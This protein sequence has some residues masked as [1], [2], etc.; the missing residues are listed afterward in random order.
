MPPMAPLS[1]PALPDLNTTDALFN[2]T[3]A[4]AVIVI[5]P[6]GGDGGS[7]NGTAGNLG[8]VGGGGGG[9]LWWLLLLLLPLFVLP[10]FAPLRLCHK[11]QELLEVDVPIDIPPEPPTAPP[12]ASR[13]PLPP[14]VEAGLSPPQVRSMRAPAPRTRPAA[15]AP[16]AAPVVTEITSKFRW[17]VDV[18][19]YYWK[20]SGG[21]AAPLNVGWGKKG[22]TSS[23]PIVVNEM[24]TLE[25][26]AGPA[27]LAP[28]VALSAK[29]SS[30]KTIVRGTAREGVPEGLIKQPS[31][32]LVT[33][34]L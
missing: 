4:T 1:P 20:G 8:T 28:Q 23:T 21:A 13:P 16:P 9:D 12:T 30:K 24:V 32:A 7:L 17:G 31:H 34:E 19:H 26:G 18:G 2:E 33:E 5:V 10:F 29:K 22:A 15:Q 6:D 3:N 14:L 11:R 27:P 25:G